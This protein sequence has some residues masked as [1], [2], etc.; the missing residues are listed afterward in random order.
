MS[1]ID[2][3]GRRHAERVHVALSD[4]EPPLVDLVTASPARPRGRGPWV[5]FAAA[6]AVL[7]LLIPVA[8]LTQVRQATEPESPIR[9]T[10]S[11]TVESEA[12]D[13]SITDFE[14]F[15]TSRLGGVFEETPE[16]IGVVVMV[17]SDSAQRVEGLL[18]EG[19]LPGFEGYSFLA[20]DVVTAAAQRFA[21]DRNLRPLD[22]D[23]VAFGLIPRFSDSPLEDWET[24]LRGVPNSVV[25]RVDFILPVDQLPDGWTA[26]TDLAISLSSGAVV[27]A[28]ETGIVVIQSGSSL[29]VGLDGSV[30]SGEAPPL[31]MA[32]SCC[33]T[34][35]LLPIGTDVVLIDE[36]LTES[37]LL[38]T[39]TMTWRPL[40][41]RPTAGYVLGSAVIQDELFVVTADT[42]TE[43]ATSSVAVL[44]ISSEEWRE[45]DPVPSPISVGGVASDGERLLVIGTRQ[46]PDNNVIGSRNPVAYE[47]ATDGW[48]RLPDVP[49]DGQASTITWVDDAGLLAW[50]YDLESAILKPSGTWTVLDDVPMN[51]AECFPHSEP[52]SGGAVG[53]CG[54]IAWFEG[55]TESWSE[56]PYPSD[57]RLVVSGDGVF[58][59]MQVSRDT[60]RFV[61]YP[62]DSAR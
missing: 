34:E 60:V 40:G 17:P 59:L 3:V 29:L 21:E 43:N 38:D 20:A 30:A 47:Y 2:E 1:D 42:R 51:T 26:I 54:G 14:S 12:G 11:T 18:T 28:V 7:A 10:D 19:S 4:V 62:L 27:E 55:A 15:A 23:W 16:R 56:I 25:V 13:W 33:G 61:K 53:L 39:E 50:N 5:A 57:T 41:Q 46:G 32:S 52:V 8:L 9:A 37:W 35:D 6:A 45:L 24:T 22:M 58:G 48:N 36:G 31:P 49:I 44:S